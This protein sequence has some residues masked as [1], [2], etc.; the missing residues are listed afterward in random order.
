MNRVYGDIDI[1]I[2][3]LITSIID[4]SNNMQSTQSERSIAHKLLRQWDIDR[5]TDWYTL[6]KKWEEINDRH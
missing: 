3:N 5:G 2:R 1:A 6:T 4:A